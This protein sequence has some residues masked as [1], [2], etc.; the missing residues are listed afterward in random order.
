MAMQLCTPLVVE[1]MVLWHVVILSLCVSCLRNQ[2]EL[3]IIFCASTTELD[4]HIKLENDIV[5][6]LLIATKTLQPRCLK[7][8]ARLPFV[9][10]VCLM[11]TIQNQRAK[12]VLVR[13][14]SL[15]YNELQKLEKSMNSAFTKFIRFYVTMLKVFMFNLHLW[16]HRI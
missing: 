13:L 15:F 10:F 14:V 12:L 4:G 9:H 7:I 16:T 8:I 1:H 2:R 11:I 5:I 6:M 3:I